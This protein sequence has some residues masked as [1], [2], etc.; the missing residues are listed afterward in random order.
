MDSCGLNQTEMINQTTGVKGETNKQKDKGVG[1]DGIQR[2]ECKGCTKVLKSGGKEYGT[3]SLRRHKDRCKMLKLRFKHFEQ[4]HFDL[5]GKMRSKFNQKVYREML[6]EAIIEHDMPF[7]YVEY[8][9]FRKLAL[10]LN[11]EI[12]II[13]RNT[14]VSDVNKVYIREKGLKVVSGGGGSLDRIR[15]SVKYVKMTE[16]KKKTFV[17]CINEVGNIDTSIG[18]RMDVSTRWNSTYLMLDSAIKYKRAFS[19]LQLNDRNYKHCPYTEDWKRAERLCEFLKPFYKITNLIS[20]SSYPTSNL[21]FMQVWKIERMLKN[22]LHD[23]DSLISDMCRRMLG[24]FEKYWSEYSVVLAFGA[25]LDPRLKLTMLGRLYDKVE[26]DPI[27]CQEKMSLLKRKLYKLFDQYV[28]PSKSGTSLSDSSN[29][30]HSKMQSQ[31]GIKNKGKGLFDD[32]KDLSSEPVR[33]VEK[34]ELDRYLDE[35]LYELAYHED[36]NVLDYW[37]GLAHVYPNLSLMARDVLAIPITTVASESAFS[38]GARV[39]TKYRNSMLPENVQSLICTRNWLHGF[40]LD[41][42]EGLEGSNEDSNVVQ[43]NDD[44]DQG[45]EDHDIDMNDIMVD[46]C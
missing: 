24:K 5:Q 11:P 9:G 30:M 3:S 27:K 45:E 40:S 38:I 28:I 8:A 21:Y 4:M 41:D 22:G 13:S 2:S 1:E 35:G 6:A 29:A 7:S 16:S 20:G 46:E 33:T 19:T 26:E 31:A 14:L 37:K 17:E 15:E 34:S 44:R 18:L 25:V 36:L 42:E 39:R 23:E 32:I 12:P 43:I 10:Y